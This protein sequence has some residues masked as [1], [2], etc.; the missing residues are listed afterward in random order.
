MQPEWM[1]GGTHEVGVA[2]PTQRQTC[3]WTGAGT[4]PPVPTKWRHRGWGHVP[5]PLRYKKGGVHGSFRSCVPPYYCPTTPRVFPLYSPPGGTPLQGR[6]G[7]HDLARVSR[8]PHL[9]HATLRMSPRMWDDAR[10]AHEG[11]GTQGRACGMHVGSYAHAMQEGHCFAWVPP[12]L[13]MLLHGHGSRGVGAFLCGPRLPPHAKGGGAAPPACP[14]PSSRPHLLP[15]FAWVG[16]QRGRGGDMALA[17]AV[18]H[19]PHPPSANRGRG[20][21]HPPTPVHVL[22]LC[23]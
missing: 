16:G 21:G 12:P 10:M 14:F 1:R 2:Q 9:S 3:G 17:L 23:A 22:C 19:P 13:C 18:V 7:V 5:P 4:V 11:W 20:R 15:S 6:G 8:V